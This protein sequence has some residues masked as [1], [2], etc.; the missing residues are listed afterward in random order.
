MFRKQ[1]VTPLLFPNHLTQGAGSTTKFL[2]SLFS[3]AGGYTFYSGVLMEFTYATHIKIRRVLSK[4][5]SDPQFLCSMRNKCQF[6]KVFLNY[7]LRINYLHSYV[8][9]KK[10]VVRRFLCL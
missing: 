1:P 9:N 7:K 3:L 5:N 4:N 8:C 6:S 10:N 2:E